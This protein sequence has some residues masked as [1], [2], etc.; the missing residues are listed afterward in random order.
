MK[1]VKPETFFMP[2]AKLLRGRGRRDLDN[3]ITN[4][5]GY[6]K[7]AQILG[8][9]SKSSKK[10]PGYWDDFSNLQEELMTFIKNPPLELTP[11]TMPTL[12]QLRISGRSDIAGAIGKHNGVAAVAE[13]LQL[14][15]I[16]ENK[17]KKYLSDW[18]MIEREVM[19][20]IEKQTQSRGNQ[21]GGEKT[22]TQK[23]KMPS[24]QELRAAGKGDLAEGIT[25]YHGGFRAVAARLKLV[26]K[27]KTD[28]YYQKFYNLATE[29][30]EFC[31]EIGIDG[32]M[33]SS[34]VLQEEKRGDLAAAI[35]KCG[36][37]SEVS[38][39]LG[40]QYQIRARE[41]LKDWILFQGNL[42]RFMNTYGNPAEIPSS[43]TLARFGRT[44]LYQAI[45]HHGGSKAVA[46]RMGVK[47]NYWQDFHCVGYELLS[48]IELHGTVGVL[49]TE[50]DLLLVGRNSLNVAVTKFGRSQVAS[51]LGLK[52]QSQTTNPMLH[53][54]GRTEES[55]GVETLGE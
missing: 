21:F 17:P 53:D 29:V 11:G 6:H 48:F 2:S 52:E 55:A 1:S 3:A 40:L 45:L 38:Q 9:S 43:S 8:W 10:V 35:V 46:D 34:A 23:K 33:P 18:K 19:D 54:I 47:R 4:F 15:R 31:R 5:G 42:Q 44:E 37:M 26:S 7:V 24:L 50:A 16:Q 12:K 27:K 14:R 49:P 30:Y 36:G 28:F 39:R 13:K 22:R 51:R 32:I 41:A 25:K 20:F